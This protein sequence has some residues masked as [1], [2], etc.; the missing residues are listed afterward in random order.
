MAEITFKKPDFILEYHAYNESCIVIN[1]KEQEIFL[2]SDRD[3]W[4]FPGRTYVVPTGVRFWF[5]DNAV[6]LITE[7][8]WMDYK[9]QIHSSITVSDCE[10]WLIV[11]NIG[12][13]PRRIHV[14]QMLAAMTVIPKIECHINNTKRQS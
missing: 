3:M 10:A 4:L 9:L 1:E 13:L 14:G 5:P 11:Q 8:I 12:F 7:N 6:G 2:S